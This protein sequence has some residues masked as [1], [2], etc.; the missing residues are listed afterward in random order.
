MALAHPWTLLL[1]LLGVVVVWLYGRPL[2]ARR[3]DVGLGTLWQQALKAEPLRAA[4]QRWRAPVSLAVQLVIL[5]LVVLAAA[6]PQIPGPRRVVVIVDNSPSM[7]ARD[8]G[9]T[10]LDEARRLAK[11]LA[12]GVRP[13][14]RLAVVSAADGVS[15]CCTPTGEPAVL[16]KAIESI[17][18]GSGPADVQTALALARQML[19]GSSRGRIVVF[20]DGRF[21]GAGEVADDD[22][23]QMVMLGRPADNLAITGLFVEPV[24]AG[25]S[26]APEPGAAE[27]Q[28]SA[29][30]EP[31]PSAR[32]PEVLVELS[33]FASQSATCRLSLQL[34]G[35]PVETTPPTPLEVLLEP[36]QQQHRLF[37]LPAKAA[38]R[39]TARIE[40]TDAQLADILPDDDSAAVELSALATP[41][42]A[43]H[44]ETAQIELQWAARAFLRLE[45]ARRE[46]DLRRGAL[47]EFD[48]AEQEGGSAAHLAATSQEA[49]Q[50]VASLAGGGSLRPAL[51]IAALLLA[52][53]QWCLEQRRWLA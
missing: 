22:Q 51:L 3:V 12:S 38:G 46:A 39:L 20:S 8:V 15:V 31:A 9:P 47:A 13:A 16:D 17:Q 11:L 41:A 18:P 1:L 6:D 34:D 21:D 19:A 44:D 28:A 53:V 33:S 42:E 26:F 14:D 4:W 48:S 43:R 45:E 49:N 30:A 5:G 2:P 35:K 32:Q 40:R 36:G 27:A 7:C 29:G 23:V 37:R 24:R 10:R 25:A 50:V 52:A